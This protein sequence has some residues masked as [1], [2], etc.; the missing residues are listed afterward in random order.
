VV[1]PTAGTIVE[2]LPEGGKEVTVGDKKYIKF[3]D[4]YYQPAQ[5]DGKDVYEVVTVEAGSK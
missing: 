3:G 5:K 2:S 1:A 4:T